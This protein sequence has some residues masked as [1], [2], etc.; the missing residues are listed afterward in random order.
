MH[1]KKKGIS[2][3]TKIILMCSLPMIILG[4]VIAFYSISV[5]MHGMQDEALS[6]LS[7]LCQSVSAS[8]DAIDSGDYRMDGEKF[9]KGEYCI[10]DNEGVIDSYTEGSKADITL[11]FGDTRRATSLL[12]VNT[13]ERI[14]GTQ[15]S[16]AVIDAVLKNGNDYSATSI[17]I[18]NQN[19]YAYYKP[20]TNSDGQIVGMIFA[21]EPSA[22]VDKVISQRRINIIGLAVLILV[23]SLVICFILVKGIVSVISHAEELLG[24]ISNGELKIQ[25]SEKAAKISEKAKNRDDEIGMMVASMYGLIE[26]LRGTVGRIRETMENLIKTSESL[27]YMAAQTSATTTEISRAI[28]EVS[29]GAVIQAEEIES[30]TMQVSDIGSMIENIVG[31]VKELDEISMGI[32]KADDESEQIIRE[33]SKSNDR[34]IEAIKKID[35]SVRTTNESVGKIQEAINLI[36]DIASETSLLALNASIEAARAGEAGRGFAVVASQISKLSEDSNSSAQT[37]EDIILQLSSDSEA[38]VKIMAEVSE[39]IAE[40]QSKLNETKDKFGAVSTGI[41]T[42]MSETQNIY[43]QTTECDT[44]RVRVTDVIENLSAVSEENAASTEETNSSM[45]EL[46]TTITQLAEA[47]KDLKTIADELEKELAFFHV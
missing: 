24:R 18:N 1:E 46:N 5:L 23:I 36:T 33:L 28:E 31:S 21:G 44:A 14:I 20:L 42:S 29:K 32:K 15:A 40:Q 30:A 12:D 35:A 22:D 43:G 2:V 37:I 41:E 38:S 3:L 27:E 13:G 4:T 45:Q 26:K 11:F 10:S 34:T 47:A 8:Y 39:I 9:Y 7:Y 16:D 6:A 17:T 25:L 19:Y